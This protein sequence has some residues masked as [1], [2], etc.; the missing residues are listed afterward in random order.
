M[1]LW[2]LLAETFREWKDDRA[3]LQGAALAFYALFAIAP[4]LVVATAVLGALFG[5]DFAEQR[6]GGE[7]QSLLTPEIT[8]TVLALVRDSAAP[9]KGFAAGSLGVI[10][11]L[12]AAA[13]G[14]IHLQATLNQVW[15]VRAIRKPGLLHLVRR[16]L[17]AFASVALCGV[18]VLA[19]IVATVA[20]HVVAQQ[21]TALV[22]P[23]VF[24]LR[25]S[26]EISA[27]LLV[28]VLLMVVYKT[29]PDVRIQWRDVVLGAAVSA[30]LF[31]FGK[32]AVTTYLR[33]VGSR[34][35][36]GAASAITAV[37]LYT[38]YMA[39]VLLF[40]AEFTFVVARWRGRPIRPGPGAAR[41]VRMTVLDDHHHAHKYGFHI[42]GSHG[43][44]QPIV[45]GSAMDASIDPSAVSTH[46]ANPIALSEPLADPPTDPGG[47]P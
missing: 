32:H 47:A 40:G 21:A 4:L 29:L 42:G 24:V 17:L 37:L 1:I 19:S 23:G 41:V 11:S 10:A 46:A 45:T 33:T 15:G 18:L 26:E 8:A 44:S 25:S 9:G 6:L 22:D 36:F 34:S 12:Y 14:F 13:R 43:L 2:E 28:S 7:L 30:M 39:Q 27:F 20:L 38:Q 3:T 35:P 31:V 5:N 16:K